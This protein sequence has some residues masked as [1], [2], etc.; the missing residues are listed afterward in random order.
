MG[1]E[2]I[3]MPKEKPP[4][5]TG[6]YVELPDG[7]LARLDTLVGSLP[8]GG[9]ADHIRLAVSRHVD[10]PPV[11]TLPPLAPVPP[12]PADAPPAKR[13]PGPKKGTKPAG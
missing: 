1:E 5:R 7:L 11:L 8:L 4:G 2:V 6:V 13:R 9:K 10:S 12:P 3:A